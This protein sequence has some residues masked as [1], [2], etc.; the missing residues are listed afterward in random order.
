MH[1]LCRQHKEGYAWEYLW[2]NWYRWEKWEL[3]A[4][5]ACLDYY[6]TVQTNAAVETHW[7]GLK[8][9]DLLWVSNPRVDLLYS[10]LFKSFLAK[11]YNKILQY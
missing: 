9:F 6:P 10:H 1:D 11:R 8:N 2:T 5:A 7:N 4:R 3:W